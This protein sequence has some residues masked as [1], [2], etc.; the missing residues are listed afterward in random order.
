[1]KNHL[2]VSLFTL[3]LVFLGFYSFNAYENIKLKKEKKINKLI[4]DSYI[5][6]Y[7]DCMNR[8]E[9]GGDFDFYFKIDSLN[10]S[11]NINKLDF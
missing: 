3:V 7:N 9:S 4:I 10:Y 5:K 2:F 1:M 6:G 11:N 8:I